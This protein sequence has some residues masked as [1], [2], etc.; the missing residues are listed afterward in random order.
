MEAHAN[1]LSVTEM[2][3][4]GDLPLC[5]PPS[6]KVKVALVLLRTPVSVPEGRRC[7]G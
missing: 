6:S 1:D 5:L 2:Q 4:T 3:A 7:Y